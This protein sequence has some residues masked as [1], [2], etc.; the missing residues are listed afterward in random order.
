MNTKVIAISITAFIGIIVLG[1]VLMPILDDATAT[2]DKFTNDGYFTYN[3]VTDDTD[4][5]FTWDPADPQKLTMGDKVLD[6]STILTTNGTLT[7]IGSD[8]FTCRYYHSDVIAGAIQIYGSDGYKSYTP[9][10]ET[11]TVTVTVT[12]TSLDFDGTTDKSYTMGNRG[13]VINFDGN[14]A[15]TLKY[16]DQAAYALKDS[17]IYLCGTTMVTGSG[18]NDFVGVFGYGSIDDGVTLSSFYGDT[19]G[20]TVSFG[21]PTITYTED[22]DH[23]D[24]YQ[25]SKVDFAL[26]QNAATVD[27][28]YSY[29]VVPTEVTAER[30][31]HFTDNQNAILGAIPIMI[32]VAILLGVVALV[33]R[34]RM[35]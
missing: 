10:N 17:E 16:S 28:T 30:S 31:V 21:T 20:N 9:S 15:L 18:T 3:A 7:I 35:E 2:T 32:I 27:A 19:G 25:I 1:S 33:I 24:L 26:T 22:P 34:S 4:V 11:A 29:F 5:T 14:G 23:I 6:M 8:N 13:F 12:N